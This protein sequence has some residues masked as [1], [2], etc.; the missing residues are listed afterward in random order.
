MIIKIYE[1]IN[2]YYSRKAWKGT[3]YGDELQ[4]ISSSW[5]RGL[6]WNRFSSMWEMLG[7]GI[8]YRLQ[9]LHQYKCLL[10]N[11]IQRKGAKNNYKHAQL[12]QIRNSKIKKAKTQPPLLKC[13]SKSRVLHVIPAHSSTKGVQRSLKP[14]L[15]SNPQILHPHPI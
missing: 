8:L 2:S 12:W 1:I 5:A 14:H 3:V 6:C 11:R 13:G 7:P 10:S 4:T 15:L 9:C